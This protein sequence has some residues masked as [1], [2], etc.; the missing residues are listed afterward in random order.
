VKVIFEKI[1]D[2]F[3][4]WWSEVAWFGQF[5]VLKITYGVI[6]LQE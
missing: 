1:L 2:I 6:I 3:V 5:V 4:F